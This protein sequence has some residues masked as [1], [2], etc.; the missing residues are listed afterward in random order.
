MPQL[1]AFANAQQISFTTEIPY[2]TS[3][4]SEVLSRA[5]LRAAHDQQYS[6]SLYPLD[7]PENLALTLSKITDLFSWQDDWNGYGALAPHPGTIID[8]GK[9]IGLFYQEILMSGQDW[10]NPNVTA[11]ADGEVVF[12]WR[13][14]TKRLTIFIGNQ[15]V[16]YVQSWGA[17][18]NNE[19]A[20]GSVSTAS[21]RCSLWKWLMS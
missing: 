14:G 20:D 12:E 9:W 11:S 16:E 1:I 10:L 7:I 19:M 21:I 2:A 3:G 8:A 15:S 6:A 4:S 5:Y 17:D 18:M 13:Q